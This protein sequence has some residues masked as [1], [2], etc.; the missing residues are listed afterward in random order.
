MA[1][2]CEAESTND[3]DSLWNHNRGQAHG[4]CECFL[5]DNPQRAIR[6]KFNGLQELTAMASAALNGL[7]RF[8]DPEFLDRRL[9]KCSL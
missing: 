7:D 5:F 8:S 2:V 9:T 6:K 4:E 1:A 3:S